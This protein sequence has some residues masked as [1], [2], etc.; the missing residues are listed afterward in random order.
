LPLFVVLGAIRP[1]M[2]R[3][4]GPE[5]RVLPPGPPAP[6][7]VIWA[8]AVVATTATADAA[9]IEIRWTFCEPSLAS[10]PRRRRLQQVRAGGRH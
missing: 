8:H 3:W 9:A 6:L 10:R 1:L 4:E 5:L 2:L 7:G